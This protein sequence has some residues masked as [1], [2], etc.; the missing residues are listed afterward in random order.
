MPSRWMS[1]FVFV[2][3]CFGAAA[4]GGWFTDSS[5]KTWY[6]RLMKPA[7]TPPS[8]AFGPVWSVLYLLMATAAWLVWQE[9][10]ACDLWLPLGLFFGQLILNAAWSF[11]FF[12][13]K[14]PGLAFVEILSLL[15]AIVLTAMSFSEY[16]R[17]AF[18]LMT[19][20]LGWVA[21]ATY[22][23]F[24]IWQLNRGVA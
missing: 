23:N 20:Y 22:L 9:R 15:L 24:G 21:Y 11:I 4:V 19:P 2:A 12:G 10:H 1:W 13:L 3:I 5:V 18:W 14:Q 7:G 6:P 17:Y 16:S 8:W